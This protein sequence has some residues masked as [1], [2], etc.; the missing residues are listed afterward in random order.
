MRLRLILIGVALSFLPSSLV[1][2]H[3]PDNAAGVFHP[4][5]N[6]PQIDKTTAVG[7]F[8]TLGLRVDND[9]SR[10]RVAVE[11]G[12]P[13]LHG[14]ALAFGIDD[15]FAFDIDETVIV[16]VE[17][18]VDNLQQLYY[19]WDKNGTA[20][21]LKK[22]EIPPG[23]TGWQSWFSRYRL[24]PLQRHR[25]VERDAVDP[26]PPIPSPI[27]ICAAETRRSPRVG[28]QGLGYR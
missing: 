6:H 10:A 2:G 20:S 23:L 11:N 25:H 8:Q 14:I 21:S 16:E 1:R 9:P 12:Q 26:G 27:T 28:D 18:K 7:V 15:R 24:R 4:E 3:Q 13:I 5:W 19:A 17:I 22:F